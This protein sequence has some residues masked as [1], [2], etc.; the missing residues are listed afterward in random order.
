MKNFGSMTISLSAVVLMASCVQQGIMSSTFQQE[1]KLPCTEKCLHGFERIEGLDHCYKMLV[2]LGPVSQDKA[3]AACGFEGGATVVTFDNPGD[4]QKLRQ[5]FWVEYKDQILSS[6]AYLKHSGFWTG[7]VRFFGNSSNPFLNMY[8]GEPMTAGLFEPG[9]PDD[10]IV[11]SRGGEACV[12]RKD[13]GEKDFNWNHVYGLDDYTCAF[14]NWAICMQRDV[15]MLNTEAWNSALMYGVKLPEDGTCQL[16]WATQNYYQ[17]LMMKEKRLKMG[18]PGAQ[19]FADKYM[20][21]LNDNAIQSP[22]CPQ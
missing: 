5:Y 9:Q 18:Y 6:P 15:Y 21:I 22:S 20:K 17:L 16:D 19:D 3:V 10:R 14:P 11:G 12:C 2:D 1:A 7:Y 8:S 13:Y 4:D